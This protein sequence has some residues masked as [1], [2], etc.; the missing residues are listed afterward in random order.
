[1][2][3]VSGG[4]VDHPPGIPLE[5]VLAGAGRVSHDDLGRRPARSEQDLERARWVDRA[6][7]L[8]GYALSASGHTGVPSRWTVYAWHAPAG[9]PS[10]TTIA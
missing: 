3:H 7:E 9:S 10:S 2:G 6:Q 8:G 1:M 4:R 5:D